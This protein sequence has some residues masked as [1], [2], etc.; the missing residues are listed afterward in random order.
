MRGYQHEVRNEIGFPNISGF[1]YGEGL[2]RGR[3][4]MVGEKAIQEGDK[5]NV[6]ESL[7]TPEE[8]KELFHLDDWNDVKIVC[9]GRHIQHYMNGRLVLDFTDSED[10]AL[11][12]GVLALQLH[13]GKPMWA[14]FKDIR[15]KSL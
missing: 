12:D 3:V 13:A 2:G 5:K 1:I 10:K 9:K 4:C 8:F 11:L 14:E 15:F 7:I 6:V